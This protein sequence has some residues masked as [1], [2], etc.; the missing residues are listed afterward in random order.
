MGIS[1]YLYPYG[2]TTIPTPLWVPYLYPNGYITIPMNG[3]NLVERKNVESKKCRKK[4]YR[5]CY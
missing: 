1:L 4:E 2:Y 5:K 3:I